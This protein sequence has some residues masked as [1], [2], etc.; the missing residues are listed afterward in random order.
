[1]LRDNQE[2]TM[3]A[4]ILSALV[5][6]LTS[7]AYAHGNGKDSTNTTQSSSK[8]TNQTK[9]ES[10]NMAPLG[11]AEAQVINGLH[12]AN[13]TEVAAGKLAETNGQSAAVK[14]YGRML[15]K[16]HTA[17]DR[18]LSSLAARRGLTMTGEA[19]DLSSLQTRKGADFDSA[20]ISEMIKGHNDAIALV[21]HAQDTCS[22]K[23]V[24]TILDQTLPVLQR[25]QS[26]AVKLQQQTYS[27]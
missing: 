6:C 11:A 9:G 18:K 3:R 15:V 14:R 10:K 22:D 5:V 7:V 23:E 13:M 21:K 17:A 1:V 27:K 4:A 19:Q 16:D 25:H 24:K 26:E 2:I 20:F 8:S 12:E